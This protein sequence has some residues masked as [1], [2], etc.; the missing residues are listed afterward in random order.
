MLLRGYRTWI[1]RGRVEK[2]RETKK[3]NQEKERVREMD[4]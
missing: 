4:R 3:I 2:G 1:R